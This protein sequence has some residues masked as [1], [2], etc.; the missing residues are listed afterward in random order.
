MKRSG[1]D[2]FLPDDLGQSAKDVIAV[3]EPYHHDS[4]RPANLIFH[5]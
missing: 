5:E 2:V 4:A 1:P 3:S